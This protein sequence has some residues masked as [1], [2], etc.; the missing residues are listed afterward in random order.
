M[1]LNTKVAWL[2]MSAAKKIMYHVTKD[3]FVA[4][5]KKEGLKP[6]KKSTN[7]KYEGA[8]IKNAIY[9]TS[10]IKSAKE[11]VEMLSDGDIEKMKNFSIVKVDVT[12]WE[13]KLIEDPHFNEFS[14]AE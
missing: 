14:D 13:K 1:S 12:P 8:Y 11:W 10:T 2:I 4:S 7:P 5:I 6:S 9:L 3:Q